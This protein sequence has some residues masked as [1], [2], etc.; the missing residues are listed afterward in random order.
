M[1]SKAIG[2]CLHN[3][4]PLSHDHLHKQVKQRSELLF[5]ENPSLFTW[6]LFK[7]HYIY[8]YLLVM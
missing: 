4:S 7:L 8:V 5:L 3:D 6:S 2:P 1:Y